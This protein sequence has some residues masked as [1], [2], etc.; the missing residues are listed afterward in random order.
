MAVDFILKP[1]WM[2]MVQQLMHQHFESVLF[3]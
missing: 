3:A 2:H 1:L